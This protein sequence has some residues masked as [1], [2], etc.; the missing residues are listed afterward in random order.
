MEIQEL[1]HQKFKEVFLHPYHIFNHPD[2][3]QLNLDK[4]EQLFYLVFYKDSKPRLG[5]IVGVRNH[6][7]LS[8]FSA[9]FGGFT[10]LKDDVKIGYIDE[11]LQSLEIWALSKNFQE[12]K[13]VLPPD[14]YHQSFVSK[15]ISAFFRANYSIAYIDLNYQFLTSEFTDNYLNEIWYNAKKNYKRSIKS[16]LNFVKED[17][18]EGK[19]SVY[20]VISRNRS[21]RGFPLRMTWEQVKI[22]CSIIPADFFMVKNGEGLEIASAIIFH[23]A[24]SKVQVIYWGDLPEFAELKTMN[25]LSYSVFSYYKSHNIEL[26]DIGPSTE[27]GLPNFGLC[28]FKESIGC[29]ISPKYTFVKKLNLKI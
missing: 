8:P 22:T 17:S 11:A 1:T 16:N 24:P 6:T 27:Y 7:L 10:F 18:E 13:V 25:F 12:I 26:V 5:L 14:C 2:F 21:E 9:P 15:Q 28:E 19:K 23:V 29:E 20:N 3:A 4:A